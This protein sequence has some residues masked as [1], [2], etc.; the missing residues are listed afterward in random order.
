MKTLLESY[1][2]TQQ[3]AELLEAANAQ[4]G[5]TSSVTVSAGEIVVFIER[6][7]GPATFRRVCQHCWHSA[8]LDS[9][10]WKCCHCPETSTRIPIESIHNGHQPIACAKEEEDEDD[11]HCNRRDPRGK[12]PLMVPLWQI[13]AAKREAELK[14]KG[15]APA[16]LHRTIR[17]KDFQRIAKSGRRSLLL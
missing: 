3:V 4:P 15:T 7:K 9:P 10:K 8:E 2:D 1:A 16:I 12:P 13:R 14:A 11:V 5:V 6:A 17:A